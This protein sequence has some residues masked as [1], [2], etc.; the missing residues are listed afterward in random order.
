MV[1]IMTDDV[2]SGTIADAVTSFLADHTDGQ[3]ALEAV[4][5]VDSETTTWTFEDIAIDSGTFGELVSRG[6]VQSRRRV[7]DRRP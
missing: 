4:L 2:D 5:A 7:S 1:L 3:R 6:I